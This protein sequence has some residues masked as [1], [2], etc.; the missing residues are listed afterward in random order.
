MDY[1]FE[2]S[3]LSIYNKNINMKYIIAQLSG[4]QFFFEENSWCDIDFVKREKEDFFLSLE[5]LLLYKKDLNIQIGK[6]FLSNSFI[7][8]WIIADVIGKKLAIIKTKQKKKYTRTKGHRQKYTRIL[9]Y[10]K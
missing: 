3:S 10:N 6:P 1:V 7:G 4:K 2:S 9:L 5:K 8:A